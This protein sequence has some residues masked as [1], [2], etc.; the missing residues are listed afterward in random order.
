MTEA[1][2]HRG[3]DQE[4][5]LPS[6]RHPPAQPS[7]FRSFSL[8]PPGVAQAGWKAGWPTDPGTS[9]SDL[10]SRCSLHLLTQ[11]L[12]FLPWLSELF[13]SLL[14]F[15]QLLTSLLLCSVLER[16]STS[17]NQHCL[18]FLW[19]HFISAAS[20]VW[21]HEQIKGALYFTECPLA[22]SI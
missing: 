22:P 8:M 10:A 20:K 15:C 16:D 14:T 18:V 21:V 7:T 12:P 5:V 11:A 2:Y 9:K 17:V 1:F 6:K 19:G 3:L 4:A 13:V